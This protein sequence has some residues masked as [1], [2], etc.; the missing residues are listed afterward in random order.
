[1]ED[2][3]LYAV[4][5]VSPDASPHSLRKSYLQLLPTAH[6]DKGG[7][8]ERFSLIQHAYEI[9]S[10]PSERA[11]YDER[12]N[13]HDS[14]FQPTWYGQSEPTT[15]YDRRPKERSFERSVV[16]S[17]DGRTKSVVHGQQW[18]RPSVQPSHGNNAFAVGQ[19]EDTEDLS[20]IIRDARQRCRH[21]GRGRAVGREVAELHLQ[22]AKAHQKAGRMHHARF[23]AMEA[24]RMEPEYEEATD[25]L[26]EIEEKSMVEKEGVGAQGLAGW[27]D[28]IVGDVDF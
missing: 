13:P 16:F 24:L 15:S 19:R 25:L 4:L 18:V 1:M 3:D 27:D 8:P 11:I 26:R 17:S 9:L 14:Q 22:R 20:C 28:D 6:P 23:D 7:D 2:E 5:G 10:D 21:N 12:H